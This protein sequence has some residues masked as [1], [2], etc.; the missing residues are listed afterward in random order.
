VVP[1]IADDGVVRRRGVAESV[2]VAAMFA[3]FAA[4][5]WE[6]SSWFSLFVDAISIENLRSR[7]LLRYLLV[8]TKELLTLRMCKLVCGCCKSGRSLIIKNFLR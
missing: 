7:L 8:L 4:F 2:G 3:S 5:W 6:A 1:Y